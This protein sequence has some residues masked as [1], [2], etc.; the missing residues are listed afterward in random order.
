MEL[1]TPPVVGPGPQVPP[2]TPQQKADWNNFLDFT[3][4]EGYMGNPILDDRNKNLGNY[5]MQKYRAL[6]PH[7]T[8]TYN[9]VPRVQQELQDYRNNL[10]N[11]YKSGH[12]VMDD[13]KSEDEIMPGLSPADGWLGSKTS[14]HR[15]PVAALTVNNNGKVATTNYG[16]DTQKY[17][18]DMA[19]LKG[20][21]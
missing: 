17:D 3:Q 14:S 8:I 5:L 9:D 12:A 20:G 6:N 4:K 19:K 11:Q 2:L 10:V 1:V 13:I 16:T 15:F 21:K 7:A 18:A